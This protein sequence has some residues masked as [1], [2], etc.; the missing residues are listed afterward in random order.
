[1]MNNDLRP[2]RIERKTGSES[3]CLSGQPAGFNLLEFW[4]WSTSDLVDNTTRGVLAEFIV[5]KAL[6]IDVRPGRV[7][8]APWDLETSKHARIEVKSAAYLQSWSQNG[9]STIQFVV[10]KR[11]AFDG[12]NNTMEPIP[13]RHADIYVFALLAH[14]DKLTLDPLDLDQWAFFV[15]PTH[16]LDER[17]RS[18]HSI[19]LRS[20][21]KLAGPAVGFP[22]LAEAVEKAIES[23]SIGCS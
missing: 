19:T 20:L 22:Q 13:R 17:K 8:W 5:A 7:G 3:F 23:Q 16:M 15:L 2:L 14:K 4:Q 6:G 1:M 9:L 18:Q 21:E 12:E 11:R 10:P